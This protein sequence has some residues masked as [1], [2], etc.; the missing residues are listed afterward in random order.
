MLGFK[1]ARSS[2]EVF[3]IAMID[4]NMGTVVELFQTSKRFATNKNEFSF[5]YINP[6]S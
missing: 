4:A 6:E 2:V 5:G 3:V 1:K